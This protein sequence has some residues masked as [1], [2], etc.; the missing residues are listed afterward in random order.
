MEMDDL[1]A[2]DLYP[3]IGVGRIPCSN[4]KDCQTVIEKIMNY[5]IIQDQ[6]EWY[7]K[8]IVMGGDTTPNSYAI[9]EGEWLQ[10]TQIIPYMESYGFELVRL[11]TSLGT[12]QPN[13]ITSEISSGA[14]FVNYAGH[15]YMDH[16][17]TYL[18]Q[19][20]TS[21]DYNIND[22]NKM[23]NEG[24]L[25]VFF[26]DACLTGKIDYDI[27]DKIM[28]PICVLYPFDFANLFKK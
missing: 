12:F 18:P 24:K 9:Y 21:I 15:G 2:V 5:D 4:Q 7:N 3:D 10:E 27:F 13:V 14:R 25:P 17:G 11:Y 28:I 19:S 23:T 8:M 16:I 26:L 6:S 1:D 22:V 20:N